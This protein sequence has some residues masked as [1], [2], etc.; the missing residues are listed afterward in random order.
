[1]SQPVAGKTNSPIDAAIARAIATIPGPAAL[2]GTPLQRAEA[3]LSRD[4]ITR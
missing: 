2:A 1:M 3:A 4:Q